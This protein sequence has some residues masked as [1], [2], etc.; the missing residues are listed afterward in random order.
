MLLE[1]DISIKLKRTRTC[2]YTLKTHMDIANFLNYSEVSRVETL[3]FLVWIYM[4]FY[5][6]GFNKCFPPSLNN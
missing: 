5:K 2:F 6:I 3:S 4:L 1:T